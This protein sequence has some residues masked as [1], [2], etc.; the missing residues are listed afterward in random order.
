MTTT[1]PADCGTDSPDGLLCHACTTRLERDLGDVPALVAELDV[2]ISR[3]DRVPSTS[4]GR[5]VTD[6]DEEP[7][8]ASIAHTRTPVG[9]RAVQA[10]DDLG[11]CLTSWARAVLNEQIPWRRGNPTTVA[12]RLLLNHIPEVRRHEA[13]KELCEGIAEGIHDARRAVDRPADRVYLG[14]CL[15]EADGP[16]GSVT[17]YEE[18][19]ASP[20]ASSVVCK[21]CRIEHPVAERRAWLLRRASDMLFTVEQ[22]SRMLGEVGGI[23]V[24]Q[25]S[26]RGYIHRKRIAYRPGGK[27]IRLGD[28]IDV[29]MDES[30]RRT[31]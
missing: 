13:V 20:T 30:E 5:R 17:C 2:T 19:F 27:T 3:Q 10:A 8:L 24:T 29:V 23:R 22:A 21:V 6:P 7:G 11:N 26:I 9:W 25:A 12:A 14:Q 28:L 15:Y 1:C 18:I 16:E 31:A 4:G